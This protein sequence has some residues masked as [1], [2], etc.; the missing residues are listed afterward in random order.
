[1]SAPTRVVERELVVVDLA[2]QRRRQQDAVVGRARLGADHGHVV[3]ARRAPRQFVGEARRRHAGADDEKT[4]R[5]M[6]D[7]AA[8]SSP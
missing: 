3:A 4:F 2:G 6:S 8:A 5:L 1:M 7:H